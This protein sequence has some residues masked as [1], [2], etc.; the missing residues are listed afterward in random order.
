MKMNEIDHEQPIVVGIDG[1]ENSLAA[2]RWAL[3][4]GVAV[5]A[6]VEVVH[7]WTPQTFTEVFGSAH[8]LETASVCMLQ[9]EVRTA[10]AEMPEAPV[11]LQFSLHGNPASILIKRSEAARMLVLGVRQTT[12][13]RDL[14][15]G[16]VVT[17][18][19]K[20]AACPV[21]TVDRLKDA[22]WHH[23]TQSR[24]VHVA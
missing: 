23:P 8:E 24:Q 18:C 1:S 2:L 10:L 14:A 4:E 16:A 7:C 22:V 21:V 15:Y 6:P 9:N 11:A 19:R 20:H 12:A 17:V 3:R 5:G 13:M